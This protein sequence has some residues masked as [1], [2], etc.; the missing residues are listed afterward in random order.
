MTIVALRIHPAIGIARIGTSEQGFIGPER[1]W[2]LAVPP[3]GRYRD[4]RGLIKRQG[5]RFHVY[6]FEDDGTVRELTA[7][8]ARITWTVHLANRKAA[9]PKFHPGR[10]VLRNSDYPANERAGL[11]IDAGEHT[12]SGPDRPAVPLDGGTFTVHGHAPEPVRLGHIRTDGEGRL[13]VL[14]G[15]GRAGS[16]TGHRLDDSGDSDEWFDDVSDGFVSATV[17][18]PGQ[19]GLP[20][21]QRAWVVVGPPKFAPPVGNVVR[22]WD[23]VFDALASQKAKVAWPSYVDDIYPVLQAAYDTGA[24]I[25]SARGAHDRFRHPVE[26][27]KLVADIGRRT[28]KRGPGHMPDLN[29]DDRQS[30][31]LRLTGT[32]LAMIERWAA[33]HFTADWPRDAGPS[34]PEPGDADTPAGLDK[35]ALENCVGRALYPGI[36]AGAFLLER[37]NYV[38][39]F[40]VG[41]EHVSFRLGPAVRPG[42]VTAGMSVP[43]QSDFHACRNNWWPA[44]R[45]DQV[46]TPGQGTQNW[47]R[48]A[49]AVEDF[50]GGRWARLGFVTRRDGELV[51][52]E[53]TL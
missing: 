46:T 42:D 27:A 7:A 18:I 34:F 24:V 32:Q 36:E 53:R 14:G 28:A 38:D 3:D 20:P 15:L 35:A 45:P 10:E 41:G 26:A 43:W 6:A 16:P 1:P 33:G 17:D 11:I 13:V 29:T 19:A 31:D 49:T 52:T 40:T 4:D 48:G 51:E 47:N 8:D 39:D 30:G 22:L 25:A 9:A 50:V 44:P 2:Q 12:I 21:V 23:T 37:T 5:A